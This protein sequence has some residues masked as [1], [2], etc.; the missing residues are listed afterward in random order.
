MSIAGR[1]CSSSTL[2][3]TLTSCTLT[4]MRSALLLTIGGRIVRR[5]RLHDRRRI[6]R[7]C[8]AVL[9]CRRT[10]RT[11]RARILRRI[12]AAALRAAFVFPRPRWAIRL[13]RRRS[14]RR[15]RLILWQRAT[16]CECRDCTGQAD[17][18]GEHAALAT[19]CCRHWDIRMQV[20]QFAS[21]QRRPRQ[22]RPTRPAEAGAVRR[23]PKPR[24]RQNTPSSK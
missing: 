15:L 11:S 17:C 5:N 19:R 8:R 9:V 6:G 24:H 20:S 14:Q 22:H 12:G 7:S 4:L 23:R 13:W 1:L 21:W 18:H 10:T 3:R 2:A 16:R